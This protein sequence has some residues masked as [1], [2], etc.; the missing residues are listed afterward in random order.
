MKT[1]KPYIALC[2]ILVLGLTL[3]FWGRLNDKI[4]IDNPESFNEGWIY[5]TQTISLPTD[6]NAPKNQS[7]QIYQVLDEAFHEPQFLMIRTSLQNITVY[8]DGDLIYEKTYGDSLTNPYASMWHFVRLPRHIEGQTLILEFSS[9]YTAMSGQISEIFYGTEAM[10]YTYLYRTYGARLIIGLLAF[11]IGF[12]I[13][14]SDLIFTKKDDRG[15]SYAGLFVILLSLWMLAESR[16]IQFFSGSTLL[17]GTLAYLIIP[18]VSIPL[19]SYLTNYVLDK[20]KK[21]LYIMRYVYFSNFVFIVAMYLFNVFDFFESVIISQVTLLIGIIILVWTLILEIKKESNQKAIKFAK[22]FGFLLIFIILELVNFARNSFHNTSVFLSVGFSIILIGIFYNYIMYLVSRLKISY[23][24]EFYEKLA[25]M[26]HV[27]QG[28]NRL[29]FERD[30]DSIFKDPSRKD[31]LRL[32]SFD[33]DDLKAINDAY[34]HVEG[35]KAIKK[36]FEMITEAFKDYGVCYR[37]GGDEFACLY[38]QIDESI[39]QT[40]AEKLIKEI[41]NYE[42]DTP[43]HFGLSLGSSVITSSEMTQED[44]IHQADLE[45]YAYKKQHKIKKT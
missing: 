8:L 34:G 30:L 3:F 12:L 32:I 6:V 4:I 5:N 1:H 36:S 27:T 9:P 28:Q 33:L 31:N 24:T 37:I 19:I 13:M 20:H 42:N 7:Y 14:I 35:D 29:A 23:E 41:N 25:Y 26:D 2:F 10:H 39:Y 22:V 16:M 21:L 43:Y 45:M 44:L 15:Y 17:I 18:L 38:E 11:I 40:Q